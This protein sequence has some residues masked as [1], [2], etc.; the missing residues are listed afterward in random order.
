MF[1]VFSSIRRHHR[2]YANSFLQPVIR[3]G[4]LLGILSLHCCGTCSKEPQ[5]EPLKRIA[6][7]AAITEQGVDG[8]SH[9]V[10]LATPQVSS[11]DVSDVSK[12]ILRYAEMFTTVIAA[13]TEVVDERYRLAELGVGLAVSDQSN[14][15]IVSG[16]SS[17]EKDVPSAN[18]GMIAKSVLQAAERSLEKI[19][20]TFRHDSAVLIDCPAI[21]A[22][23]GKHRDFL[24]RHL[25]WVHPQSGVLS[26]A[27]WF[28]DRA[29]IRQV[30]D[31]AGVLLPGNFRE[32]RSLHV[33][34]REF[35]FG[36]PGER[37]FAMNQL[38]GG[39]PFTFDESSAEVAASESWTI[40]DLQAIAKHLAVQAS[41]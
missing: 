20:I 35:L 11:G 32:K 6:T 4:C 16:G 17:D 23:D 22:V 33:L 25:V 40:N 31:N 21:V 19:S 39:K 30:L 29:A 13:N 41:R 8:W 9:L 38:P 1:A 24:A 27:V 26:S 14:F 7:G 36:I 3:L 37:A 15:R 34:R 2:L 12:M 10:L 28:V 5:A 18:L